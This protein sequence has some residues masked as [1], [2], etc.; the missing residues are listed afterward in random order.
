[1][2]R[3]CRVDDQRLRVADVGQVAN[4]FQ[5]VDDLSR[6]FGVAFDAERQYA[7]EAVAQVF[8][9]QR[10][11]RTVF[12]AGIIDAFDLRVFFEPLRDFQRVVDAALYSQRQRFEALQQLKGIERAQA[13]SQIAQSF[14]TRADCERDVAEGAVAARIPPIFSARC[15]FRSVR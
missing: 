3:R 1:M 7:A 2:C 4:Q 11:V 8:F 9:C 5:V 10:V 12:E 6:L 13:R 14:G 15:S